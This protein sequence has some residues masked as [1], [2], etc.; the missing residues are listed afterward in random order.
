MTKG[1]FDLGLL[2]LRLWFGLEMA[3]AHG[4]PKLMKLLDGDMTFADP[5]GIGMGLSLVLAVFGEFICGVL[6]ALGFFTRVSLIPYLITMLV[7]IFAVHFGDPYAKVAPALM[8]T[9]GGIVLMIT[10]P[11]RFSLDQYL[12]VRTYE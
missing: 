4:W 12:F 7:A 8:Y 3:F 6:I 11:G 2:I 9:I 1:N 5:L 10:G